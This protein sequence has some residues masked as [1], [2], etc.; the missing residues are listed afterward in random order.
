MLSHKLI[1]SISYVS[2]KLGYTVLEN[3]A[4]GSCKDSFEVSASIAYLAN[5][6]Y[7]LHW[8]WQRLWIKR[9]IWFFFWRSPSGSKL[10]TTRWRSRG[11]PLET[12][13]LFRRRLDTFYERTFNRGKVVQIIFW[14]QKPYFWAKWIMIWFAFSPHRAGSKSF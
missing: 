11:Q 14:R 13:L 6:R 2:R 12:D 9:L 10:T 4:I 1:S 3:L 5:I 7:G 8:N